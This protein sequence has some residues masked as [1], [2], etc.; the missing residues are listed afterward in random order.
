MAIMLT[1]DIPSYKLFESEKIF[2]FLDIGPI[3]EGHSLV[4]PKYHAAKIHDVPDDILMEMLPVAKKIALALGAND[5][6]NYNLL[7]N[8]GKL[9]HQEVPHVHLHII[10]KP[11]KEEGLTVGWPVQEVNLDALKKLHENLLEKMKTL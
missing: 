8:N 11:N 2:A 6:F 4:I 7:Q 10:P 9:A 5:S 1:G 3:S